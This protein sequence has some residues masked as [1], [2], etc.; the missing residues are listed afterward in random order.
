[1]KTLIIVGMVLVLIVGGFFAVNALQTDG[2]AIANTGCGKC[3][4]SCTA[5]SNCGLASCGAVNGGECT[6]DKSSS[7]GGS[8][9][10][11]SVDTCGSSGCAAVQGTGSCGCGK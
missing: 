3:N 5:D 6:C 11:G 8:C 4:G 7:C 9:Q 2:N 1:M 10:V